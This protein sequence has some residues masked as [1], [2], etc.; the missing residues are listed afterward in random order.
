MFFLFV[1]AESERI[2]LKTWEK[3]NEICH[4]GLDKWMDG[5]IG[6]IANANKNVL[7]NISSPALFLCQ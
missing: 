5:L 4:G 6:A 1:I 7:C 2:R 3:L